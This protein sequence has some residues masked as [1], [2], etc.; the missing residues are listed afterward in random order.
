VR[1]RARA[2]RDVAAGTHV[3]EKFTGEK[4]VLPGPPGFADCDLV[5]ALPALRRYARKLARG[6]IDAEDLVADVVARALAKRDLY[7]P[8]S[9]LLS[10][11]FS[12]LYH[13]YV[14]GMRRQARERLVCP[15][16]RNDLAAAASGNPEATAYAREVAVA[17]GRLPQWQRDVVAALVDGESYEDAAQRLAIPVGTFRS[18]ATRARQKI[19]GMCA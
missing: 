2:H 1:D 3:M 7:F 4:I 8:T 18:R 17:I 16:R 6:N 5:A 13:Q 11:L 12:L 15:E 9:P 19:S 10:W 14:N